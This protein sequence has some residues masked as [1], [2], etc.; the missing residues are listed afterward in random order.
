MKTTRAEFSAQRIHVTPLI[1]FLLLLIC[2]RMI[3]G[4]G[5]HLLPHRKMQELFSLDHGLDM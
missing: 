4:R 3:A 1:V 5:R 2:F